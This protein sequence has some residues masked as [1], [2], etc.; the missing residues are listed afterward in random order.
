MKNV[1]F[2]YNGI[3]I[4]GKLVKGHYSMG[5]YTNGAKICFYAKEYTTNLSD[6]FQIKNGT[7]LIEDYHET[8]KVYFYGNEEYY[9]EVEQAFYKQEIK[10][11]DKHIKYLKSNI[12]KYPH[13]FNFYNKELQDYLKQIEYYKSQ[14]MN[15]FK[16]E[17]FTGDD[18]LGFLCY[19]GKD[20]CIG[21]KEENAI[22]FNRKLFN[23]A[24]IH[25]DYRVKKHFIGA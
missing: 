23:N 5:G 11:S 2:M 19:R 4:N 12:E 18:S 9:N 21:G 7:E 20:I 22:I 14:C 6:V 17:L 3:K 10:R 16:V 15:Q 8:D 24:L 1:K 13:A 25:K